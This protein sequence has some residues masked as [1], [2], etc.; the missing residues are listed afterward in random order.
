MFY[1]VALGN[2]GEQYVRTRH[3]VG[4]QALDLAL[5]AWGMPSVVIDK[6]VQGQVTEGSVGEVFVRVLYPSTFMNHSGRAVA[7]FVPRSALTALIVVHD[8]IDLPLGTVKVAKGRGAGGNNGV[9]SIIAALGSKDFVRVRIGI[10]PKSMLTGAVRR[11]AGGGPLERFVLQPFGLLER[12]QLPAVYEKVRA[13]LEL[14][15]CEGV[16]AAMNQCN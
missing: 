16:E 3:N 10:A 9:A 13:A 6:A 1:I 15:M 4:W 8:D 12:P 2:P 7:K 14:I 5:Q 11:P